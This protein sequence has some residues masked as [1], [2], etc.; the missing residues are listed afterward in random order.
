MANGL[1]ATPTKSSPAHAA[2]PDGT[3]AKTGTA[4]TPAKEISVAKKTTRKVA[5][6]PPNEKEV[7]R[8]TTTS[9]VSTTALTEQAMSAP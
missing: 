7:S 1:A 9:T 2:T 6:R 8:I 4:A 5:E 3:A